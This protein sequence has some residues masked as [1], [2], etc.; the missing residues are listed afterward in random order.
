MLARDLRPIPAGQEFSRWLRDGA[1]VAFALLS[2]LMAALASLPGE[3]AAGQSLALVF[4]PWFSRDEA[5]ARSL[6]AGHVVLRTGTSPFI[7]IA[8][9][10][11]PGAAR[12]PR[13]DGA[14]LVLTLTGLA[15]CLDGGSARETLS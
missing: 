14:L 4:P 5:T 7:V 13:P 8:A 1:I 9:P 3:E 12:P 6:A 11:A 15:G 10:P 2:T